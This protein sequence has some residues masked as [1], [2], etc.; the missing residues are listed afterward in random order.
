MWYIQLNN[1]LMRAHHGVYDEEKI[2]GTDFIV[3]I[4]V[5]FEAGYINQMQQTIDYVLLYNI[6]ET[7]MKQAKP[8]LEEVVSNI[9]KEIKAKIIYNSL[10]ISIQKLNPAFGKGVQST[11]V[12]FTE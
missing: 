10:Y 9:A 2:L 6:A 1:V 5:G 11:E 8:L 7:E 12:I 4:K 3:N